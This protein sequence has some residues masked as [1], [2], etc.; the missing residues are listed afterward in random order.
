MGGSSHCS[1]YPSVL[2]TEGPYTFIQDC[3][4][5]S[6]QNASLPFTCKIPFTL[7]YQHLISLCWS[8]SWSTLHCVLL[9]A[10]SPFVSTSIF[11][12]LTNEFVEWMSICLPYRF[13]KAFALNENFNEEFQI[14]FFQINRQV[15]G[16]SLCQTLLF[17]ATDSANRLEWNIKVYVWFIENH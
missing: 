5:A 16:N 11:A 13:W 2:G 7:W 17:S 8:P 4:P 1:P 14:T 15:L 9:W 12:H 10:F 6:C 3:A